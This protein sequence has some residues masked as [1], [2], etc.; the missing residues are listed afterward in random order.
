[1]FFYAHVISYFINENL[2]TDLQFYNT[3]YVINCRWLPLQIYRLSRLCWIS[4]NAIYVL[5]ISL[6]VNAP[7]FCVNS[8]FMSKL[9]PWVTLVCV[10]Y[11]KLWFY[12][13]R[14]SF[15]ERCHLNNYTYIKTKQKLYFTQIGK[16][17]L[18]YFLSSMYKVF[19]I[20][21]G[22]ICV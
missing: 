17:I 21:P 2:S 8:V 3:T 19:Q 15:E 10:S 7:V 16:S 6:D 9:S 11:V 12:F 5:L 4:Q 20:W 18:F 1:M 13:K 14:P 22:L